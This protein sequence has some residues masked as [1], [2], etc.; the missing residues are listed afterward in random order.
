MPR[1]RIGHGERHQLDA[2]IARQRRLE[3]TAER[4]IGGLEQDL[5]VAARQHRADIAGAGRPAVRR[6]LHRNRG[7]REARA[8]KHRARDLRVADEMADM[9]EKYLAPR[10]QLRIVVHH[11]DILIHRS[12][13]LCGHLT[14][15]HGGD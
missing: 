5:H 11:C 14:R 15:L 12:V 8:D 10:R 1:I 9:V 7:R 2:G 13:R 6:D 3:L 4:R